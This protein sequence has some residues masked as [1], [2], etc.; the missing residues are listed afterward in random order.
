MKKTIC[1]VI[2]LW[3]YFKRLPKYVRGFLP[4]MGWGVGGGAAGGEGLG[5]KSAFRGS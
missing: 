1:D 5:K 2:E 4:V 3:K